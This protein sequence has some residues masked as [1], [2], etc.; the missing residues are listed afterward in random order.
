MA[1][2]T[3]SIQDLTKIL[4]FSGRLSSVHIKNLEAF[5]LIYF[6]DHTSNP[7]LDYT[8]ETNDKSKPTIF[9]YDLNLNLETNDHLPKRYKAL[10]GAVRKLFWKEA[11]VQIKINGEEVYKSE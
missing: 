1:K 3:P 2:T 7:K 6:N 8:I 10:E 4:L 11:K 9:S 5:P